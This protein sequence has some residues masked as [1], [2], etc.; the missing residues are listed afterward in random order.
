MED[1]KSVIGRNINAQLALKDK[2]QYELA[3]HLG[4]TPNT[5]SYFCSGRRTPNIEQLIKIADFFSVS[6][7][8]LLG[9]TPCTSNADKVQV[10]SNLTQLS[11]NAVSNLL[12]CDPVTVSGFME[13]DG[14]RELF[15]DIA[16]LYF[17][18]IALDGSVEEGERVEQYRREH[19]IDVE[20]IFDSPESDEL[21]Y[22]L[23]KNIDSLIHIYD[24]TRLERY[25]LAESFTKL[26]E[27]MIPMENTLSEAKNLIRIYGGLST[28]EGGNDIGNRS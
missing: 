12:A 14:F 20:Q 7:D 21:T 23:W 18:V 2:K 8:S 4:V 15:N 25:E 16:V 5:I 10:V 11:V 19:N 13:A 9:H 24:M 26:L 6:V 1:L 17:S 27:N 28:F 3:E 22:K